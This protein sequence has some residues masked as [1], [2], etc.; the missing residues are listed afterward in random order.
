MRVHP[1]ARRA[2]HKTLNALDTQEYVTAEEGAFQSEQKT[3][4]VRGLLFARTIMREGS[5]MR[6]E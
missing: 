6:R 5:K 1:G 2:P 4:P 3:S